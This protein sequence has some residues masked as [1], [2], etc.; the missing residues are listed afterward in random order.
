M[1]PGVWA[2]GFAGRGTTMRSVTEFSARERVRA[3]TRRCGAGEAPGEAVVW[4]KPR[5]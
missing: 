3:E 5:A 1:E 2:G 4:W